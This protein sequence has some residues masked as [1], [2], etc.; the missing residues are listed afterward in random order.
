[1]ETLTQ[2]S[3]KSAHH[4]DLTVWTLQGSTVLF[5]AGL[6]GLLRDIFHERVSAR[7]SQRGISAAGCAA[8]LEQCIRKI[9]ERILE[10]P[11]VAQE[12]DLRAHLSSMRWF[13]AAATHGAG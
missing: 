7:G 10:T 1:M 9:F 3:T 13:A 8:S 11:L 5:R 6:F 4:H 2:A 12:E